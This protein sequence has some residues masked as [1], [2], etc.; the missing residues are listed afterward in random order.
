MVALP[1]YRSQNYRAV[2]ECANHLCDASLGLYRIKSDYKSWWEYYV[3]PQD[4]LGV[5]LDD[6]PPPVPPYY[7]D[8]SLYIVLPVYPT[9]RRIFDT[10]HPHR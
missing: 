10:Y 9:D 5:Y 6:E 4:T 3:Y 2:A 8:R 7:Y 1:N